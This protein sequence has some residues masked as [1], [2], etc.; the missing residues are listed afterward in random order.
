MFDAA[1]SVFSVK[2]EI[3]YAQGKLVSFPS[4]TYLR[5]CLFIFLI[6]LYGS[7][8]LRVFSASICFED[9]FSRPQ[10]SSPKCTLRRAIEAFRLH[11][12]NFIRTLNAFFL[13]ITN[14]TV[15]TLPKRKFY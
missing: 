7:V 6:I 2:P 8:F 9:Q 14:N 12:D 11:Q 4:V 3:T 13:S 1:V 15:K 10:Q 5:T